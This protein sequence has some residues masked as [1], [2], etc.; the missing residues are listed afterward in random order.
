MRLRILLLA[1]LLVPAGV[2]AQ[3]D[4]SLE[5]TVRSSGVPGGLC[6]QVGGDAAVGEDLAKTGRFLV[7]VIQSDAGAV[8]DARARLNRE[9][10]YGLISVQR[11]GSPARLPYAENLVNLVLLIER[12]AP[13]FPL[14]EVR[15]VLAPNG[16]LLA[17]PG[18]AGAEALKAAG[19]EQVRTRNG[20]V[21][22]RNPRPETIDEW[23]HS[24]H[25]ASGNPVSKDTQVGPP[26]RVRWVVGAQ[27][28][29][30]GMVSAGGRNFYAAA[31]A[32]DGFNGLRLW[33]RDL[34]RPSSKG[35][36]VMRNPSRRVPA[37]VATDRYLFAVSGKKLHALDAR[38]G[39]TVRTYPDAKEPRI[40]LHD[41]GALFTADPGGVR[42]LDVQTAETRWS[43]KSV[44]ARNLVVGEDFVAFIRGRVRRGEKS[45]LVAVEKDSGR[46][47]WTRKDYDWSEKISRCVAYRD[48]L[49]YEVSTLND[50]GPGNALH[51]LSA[52][53]GN[54]TVTHEFFPGMNHRRQ[55][56][57]MFVGDKLWVLHGGKDAE[58]VRHRPQVTSIDFRT[59]EAHSTFYAG[60]AHCFPPI[61]TPNYIFAGELDL[62]DL[63][64]GKIDANRITKAACGRDS[65]WIPANG[66]LYIT[67]KHCICWPMLRGY[68]ALAPAR[69]GEGEVLLKPSKNGVRIDRGVEPPAAEDA[70]PDDWPAYRHDAWRSGS[71]PGTGPAALDPVWTADL[72]STG[73]AGPIRSDWKENPFIKGAVTAPVIAGDLVCLARP[74][75]HEVVALD[76][77]TGSVRWRFTADGRVDTAPTLHRGLCLF[78]DKNGR[79]YCLRASDGKRV[80][81]LRAAPRDERIV[82]YGQ[83]ESP[84]PVPGSVLVVDDVAYFAAGR[85]SFADGGIY[86]FAVESRTGEVKW[87]TTLDSIPQK[88]FYRSSGLEFD[89]FD[90]LHREGKSVAMSRWLFDRDTGKMS[91][92][93]WRAF[94]RLDTGGGAAMVPQGTW[95]Y[96]PRHQRRISSHTALRSLVVFR[97]RRVF[98]SLQDKKTL[99][100]RDFDLEGGEEFNS[101][102]MTGWSA[103]RAS[104]E[105]KMPWRTDRLAEK[106]A[107]KVEAF[108]D[109]EII[110]MVLAGD[111]IFLAGSKGELQVRSAEDG[112]LMAKS[113]LSSPLWDGMAV[114]GGRL[115]VSTRDGK[116]L[117][118]GEK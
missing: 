75:A 112:K 86:I 53:D 87:V 82:A 34:V 1:A 78:G 54:P 19:F 24:R 101:K 117:C 83:V 93:P 29:V 60:L 94:A 21:S 39:E 64:T 102:W 8:R 80:W 81:R 76:R 59:G 17:R 99:F 95:S 5:R 63:K 26:R 72:G 65:G 52:K 38:T 69:P 27:S 22:A 70:R 88:G 90:L 98:G 118:L 10:L 66:L 68:V 116:L 23:T 45:E 115:Y 55:A 35:D 16:L 13:T 61:A 50:D 105:G 58:K 51:L 113:R 11:H 106:A 40:V 49:A 114:A 12:P 37:P 6:V 48:V 43:V 71:T 110:A 108:P 100:R 3:E 14:A 30:A 85:Q 109:Q 97:D 92:D 111:R 20:W 74:D 96:A 9:G 4:E 31:L 73:V 89:N 25:S 7:H 42:A 77:R 33:H 57:A 79:V 56:R 84:W 67:P 32:R 46:I 62:T 18:A 36:F 44:D 47:R 103:G 104:R 15:R 2:T 41:G 28:E 91:I 107:W